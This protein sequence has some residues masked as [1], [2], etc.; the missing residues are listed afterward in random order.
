MIYL[1]HAAT[2]PIDARVLDA[3]LPWLKEGY[4]HPFSLYVIGR[5]A[6]HAVERARERLAAFIG[7]RATEIVFTSSGTES[8][9]LALKGAA[10]HLRRKGHHIVSTAIEHQAALKACE[11]LERRGFEVTRVKPDE[12]GLVH[13]D[14]VRAA[15]RPD[16]I[17]INVMHA[18]NE[19]GVIQPIAEIGAMAREHGIVFHTDA[20]MSVGWIPIDV[21]KLNVDLL[22]LS[23]HKFYGPKG[24]GALY[25]RRGCRLQAL[26]DGGGQE[27]NR[28]SGTEN[29]AG[30]VGLA[31]ACECAEEAFRRG[32]PERLRT[33]RDALERGIRE[34]VPNVLING[35]PTRRLPHCLN[36]SVM[37][38]E[39]E[40]VMLELDRAGICVSTGSACSSGSL[41]PSHVLLSMGRSIPLAR[42]SLRFTFGRD[43][44]L[45]EVEQVLDV[46]P[47]IVAQLRALSPVSEW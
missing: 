45:G 35:H 30:I 31:Q 42:G 43:N 12:D 22:S 14:A 47:R 37:G 10:E 6:R 11:A 21:E 17:L 36:L 34:R 40:A 3:M 20:A 44:T 2:T 1:D 46:L 19:T 15:I 41:D 18:N 27:R 4:G 39:G 29:V 5:E 9:N 32:E 16:T 33:M 25:V 28:R 24:I 13:P 23:A 26:I 38:I 7:A 8:C